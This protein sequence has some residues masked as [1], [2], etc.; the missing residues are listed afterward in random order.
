MG[1]RNTWISHPK[2]QGEYIFPTR[3]WGLIPCYNIVTMAE[4]KKS[5]RGSDFWQ[6][7]FPTIVGAVLLVALG[8]WFGITGSTESLSRFAEIS[9]VLLTIPVYIAALLFALVLVGLIFL[10][11]KLIQGIPSITGRV[12]QVLDKIQD[13]AAQVSRFLARLVIEPTAI[14]AIFQRKR[15]RRDPDIKLND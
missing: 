10:A 7:L 5:P 2:R 14:L 6:I 15:D 3:S 13:G 1:V 9:T 12:L 4:K 8:V 11:S